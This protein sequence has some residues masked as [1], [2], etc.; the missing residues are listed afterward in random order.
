MVKITPIT[1]VYLAVAVQKDIQ[2]AR[3]IGKKILLSPTC[4]M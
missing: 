4:H 1:S 2:L 3:R